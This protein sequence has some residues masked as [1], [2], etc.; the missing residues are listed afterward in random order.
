M[1]SDLRPEPRTAEKLEPKKPQ[2]LRNFAAGFCL[3]G[4]PIGYYLWLSTWATHGSFDTIGT[5]KL[6]VAIAIPCL[7]GVV[8]AIWGK[9]V[10]DSLGKILEG[11][12]G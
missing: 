2:R 9:P 6:A 5:A 12:P 3:S 11:L 7:G 8:A 4:I 10:V 1:P